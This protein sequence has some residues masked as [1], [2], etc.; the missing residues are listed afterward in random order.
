MHQHRRGPVEALGFGARDADPEQDPD[1]PLQV[2]LDHALRIHLGDHVGGVGADADPVRGLELPASLDAQR[3]HAPARDDA[4]QDP[5]RELLR[6][7]GHAAYFKD[8]TWSPDGRIL[9]SASGDNTA[10][11]WDSRPLRERLDH[12]TRVLDAESAVRERVKHLFEKGRTL[13]EVLAAIDGDSEL[14]PLRKQAARNVL[15]RLRG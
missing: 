5:G 6:R 12:M 9:A 3:V 4:A 7:Q 1:A 15:H 2:D 11:L 8:L 10:R 14:G 13:E